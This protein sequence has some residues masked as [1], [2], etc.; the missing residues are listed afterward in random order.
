VAGTS[1]RDRHP[2]IVEAAE[3]RSGWRDRYLAFI[4]RH[5]I[6]WE[7]TMAA[8]A[9]AFVVVGFA[10]DGAD[11]N[12]RPA[13]ETTELVLTALFA[14]EFGTRFLA[15]YDRIGYLRSHWI[16]LVALIPAGRGL[17]IFRLVRLLRLVRAFAGVYRA[18]SH[19]G[20]IV[21]H[22]SLGLLVTAW[23]GVM[24]LCSAGLYIAENGVNEA[25]NSPL[26]ALWWGVTTITTVGYGDVTPV[27]PEGRL[28][29]AILMLLG[30]GL[31][32]AITATVTSYILATGGA[33][34]PSA[35]ERLR[36]LAALRDDGLITE[37]EFDAKRSDLVDNL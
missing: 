16:D 24:V 3:P 30:I 5:D 8:L 12:S 6:A 27:T 10:V 35:A 21:H 18:A 31:F 36:E 11:A 22:R 28:A 26:D 25:I 14:A 33:S 9:V 29:A 7:L 13:L 32:G 23:L 20:R 17:R 4:G 37:A 2:V 34:G 19:V 1:E 15:S